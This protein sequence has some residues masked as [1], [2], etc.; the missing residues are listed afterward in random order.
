MGTLRVD[1]AP[2]KSDTGGGSSGAG[3]AGRTLICL[4]DAMLSEIFGNLSVEGLGRASCA[5][6]HLRGT[7]DDERLW[8]ALW[9]GPLPGGFSGG[10][11]AAHAALWLLAK[12]EVEQKRVAVCE[13]PSP[14]RNGGDGGRS[15][16][17]DRRI[18]SRRRVGEV[19]TAAVS[20]GTAASSARGRG[21]M[22]GGGAGW[23]GGGSA[24][25]AG[26][27]V[28]VSCMAIGGGIIAAAAGSEITVWDMEDA[29]V[30]RARFNVSGHG[31]VTCL[32]LRHGTLLAG[33]NSGYLRCYDLGVAG[34]SARHEIRTHADRVTTMDAFTLPDGG[35]SSSRR[36]SSTAAAGLRGE[37]QGGGIYGSGHR[38][39]H[40]R[41]A[42]S[43]SVPTPVDGGGASSAGGQ[44]RRWDQGHGWGDGWLVDSSEEREDAPPGAA[45]AAAAE[46][47]ATS[48][49]EQRGNSGGG[50]GG[51]G[52]ASSFAGSALPCGP[53]LS[54]AA[55]AAGGVAGFGRGRGR[56][57]GF[58]HGPHGRAGVR[59]AAF[60][61][62][63]AGLTNGRGSSGG[64]SGIPGGGSGGGGLDGGLDRRC[65]SMHGGHGGSSNEG[66]GGG[67]C[68]GTPG[69]PSSRLGKRQGYAGRGQGDEPADATAA[70]FPRTPLGREAVGSGAAWGRVGGG[71]GSGGGM[72]ARGLGGGDSGSRG[73]PSAGAVASAWDEEEEME[74][75]QRHSV[76]GTYHRAD[77]GGG[78][79]GGGEWGKSGGAGGSYGGGEREGE[80]AGGGL[81]FTGSD[82]GTAKA[83][84]AASGRLVRVYAGHTRGVTCLQATHTESYGPVLV[85]G[86]GDSAVIIWGLATGRCLEKLETEAGLVFNPGGVGPRVGCLQAY[87]DCIVVGED[88]HV[89]VWS[90]REGQRPQLTRAS[91]CEHQRPIRRL[92]VVGR[93]IVTCA[94][95]YVIRLWDSK[96]GVCVRELGTKSG[97]AITSFRLSGLRLLTTSLFDASV[98]MTSFLPPSALKGLA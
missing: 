46:A 44:Q 82:D 26:F 20:S 56:G 41:A 77:P 21:Y 48:N 7:G 92:D 98:L 94:G 51:G 15:G 59:A 11:K 89:S 25:W 90:L 17:H 97:A 40:H 96:T 8:I 16:A 65:R 12:G 70:G 45:A 76:E 55:G 75:V 71:R 80:G 38:A 1:A 83:W 72:V 34:G 47:K 73:L 85:T 43:V 49:M 57:G 69:E 2:L 27:P 6:R 3:G 78:G 74:S 61:G 31:S 84:D 19:A 86:G 93:W 52:S 29:A 32:L 67:L 39:R 24:V 66:G 13:P 79:G 68:A 64:L 36:S 23:G 60:G 54:G 14:A 81:L 87:N 91:F 62:S 35:T 9:E 58:G 88:R 22:A 63:Q 4:P 50:G 42:G 37:A 53:S 30:P 28:H 33:D 5:C 95:D 10:V 18:T